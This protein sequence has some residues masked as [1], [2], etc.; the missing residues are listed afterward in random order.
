MQLTKHQKE[1]LKE[2][3]ENNWTVKKIAN[4]R[5]ISIQAVYKTI[6]QIKKKGKWSK[7]FE[8][9]L[10]SE[11]Y[12]KPLGKFRLHGEHYIISIIPQELSHYNPK[13]DRFILD[14]NTVELN[15]SNIEIYSN[16]DFYGTTVN[17]CELKSQ[18]YWLNFWY[19]LENR[20]NIKL[21]KNGYLN[22]RRVNKHFEDTNNELA[23]DRNQYREKIRCIGEDGKTWLLMDQSL[24]SNSLE[25][26]HPET[27]KHDMR[28]IIVPTFND[29]K[30]HYD[31]TGEILKMTDILKILN[32]LTISQNDQSRR[33]NNFLDITSQYLKSITSKEKKEPEEPI[34]EFNDYFG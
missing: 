19:K 4:R 8:R 30:S 26:T 5:K 10:K 27:S 7:V 20:L 32:T 25:T 14:G 11:T 12:T 13:Q 15:K 24:D 18:K 1:I 33:F 2:Y 16:T 34:N 6:N 9:G 29:L 28:H 17:E 31:S 23:K 22:I 3:F 21:I